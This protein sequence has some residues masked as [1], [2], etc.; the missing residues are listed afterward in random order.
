V[1]LS[2]ADLRDVLASGEAPVPDVRL[3]VRQTEAAAALLAQADG[4]A[5]DLAARGAIPSHAAFW[6]QDEAWLVD[7]TRAL[8]TGSTVPATA[9]RATVD[10]WDALRF[11]VARAW[12]VRHAGL[13]VSLGRATGQ[14]RWVSGPEDTT[15][16]EPGDILIVDHP[17]PALAPFL[18]GRA[19]VVAAGG[20]PGSHLCEVARSIHVPMV[21]GVEVQHRPGAL[22]ALDGSTGEAWV[23]EP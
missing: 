22:V 2:A 4:L 16:L 23:W 19:G 7:A 12:G 17:V 6:W 5:T 13:P 1:G 15:S 21:V 9:P 3:D 18:W 10:R 20:S 11:G 14:A 8:A